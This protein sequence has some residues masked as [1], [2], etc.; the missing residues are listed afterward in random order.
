VVSF[1]P[2]RLPNQSRPKLSPSRPPKHK[3][4]EGFLMGPIPWAWLQQ[5]ARQPGRALH[6][7]I[8]LWR[9][10]LMNRTNT[11][12]VSVSALE[13]LGVERH[14]ASRALKNLD[15]AGLIKAVQH[16]GRKP[17]ITLLPYL[18]EAA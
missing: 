17:R 10:A 16:S 2:L 18:P 14:T 8:F 12:T 4:G 3:R 9:F 11:L 13:E 6:V 5:A 1:D 15:R 7:A